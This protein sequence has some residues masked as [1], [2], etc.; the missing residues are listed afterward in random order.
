MEFCCYIW[1][2][3]A[4][5]PLVCHDRIQKRVYLIY[6]SLQP[7]PTEETVHSAR[8]ITVDGDG[9]QRKIKLN[10]SVAYG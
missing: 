2:W 9:Q 3:A 8:Y 10:H 4:R 5:F 6:I 1:P 7:F